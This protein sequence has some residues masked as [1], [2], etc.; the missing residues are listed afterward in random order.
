MGR[1]DKLVN[2]SQK[3]F[4]VISDYNLI[5]VIKDMIGE[6]ITE[7]NVYYDGDDIEDAIEIIYPTVFNIVFNSHYSNIRN[8][9]KKVN[10]LITYLVTN[11]A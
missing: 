2:N 10:D 3:D 6:A 4:S 1:R 8:N 7:N 5:Y 11:L 9:E